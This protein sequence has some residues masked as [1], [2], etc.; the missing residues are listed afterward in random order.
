MGVGLVRL[1]RGYRLLSRFI[2]LPLFCFS[3]L[4]PLL[5]A[6]VAAPVPSVVQVLLL[7]S[8][9]LNVH[10]YASLLNDIVD[11]PVDRTQPWRHDDP[12]VRGAIRPGWALGLVLI[13]IPFALLS[14]SLLG[15]PIAAYLA[16]GVSFV[17]LT[18]YDV[19]G[20]RA[21]FPPLTDLI[22]GFGWGML[23]VYGAEALPP[24]PSHVTLVPFAFIALFTAL[25]NGVH[26]GL[27]DLA[28]DFDHDARTTAILL[29]ARPGPEGPRLSPSLLLYG[30]ALQ[31]ALAVVILLPLV[32]SWFDY[33]GNTR[34]VALAAALVM[35]VLSFAFWCLLP[36]MVHLRPRLFLIAS[37]H[38]FVMLGALIALLFPS[39]DLRLRIAVLA[40]FVVPL[41]TGRKY[42]ESPFA[43]RKPH[44]R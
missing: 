35:Q 27:R 41:L 43:S 38:S 18:T 33:T 25:A 36:R 10:I 15:A 14:T 24:G 9:A 16:L 37:G 39:L 23:V 11:L 26:G 34:S 32:L 42:P 40:V 17:G 29:G 21:A 2:R 5:G 7:L 1:W 20:K 8:V 3:G 44:E 6:A 28:N 31:G 12:L 22:Q 30:L 19:W 13:Q 4:L